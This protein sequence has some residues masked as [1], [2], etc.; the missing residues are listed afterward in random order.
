MKPVVE[1]HNLSMKY[2][3]LNGE[4]NALENINFSVQEGEFVCIVG[5]SG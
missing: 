1:V 5:P 4:I 2:Q 3:S